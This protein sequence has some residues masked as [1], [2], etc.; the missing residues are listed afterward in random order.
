MH[1]KPALLLAALL[2]HNATAAPRIVLPQASTPTEKFA[3]AELQRYL[4]RVLGADVAVVTESAG[5]PAPGGLA[6]PEPKIAGRPNGEEPFNPL[7]GPADTIFV[8]RCADSLPLLDELAHPIADLRA[9]SFIMAPGADGLRLLGGGDRGT[10]YAVYAFLERQGCRWYAPGPAGEVVPRR[11]AL[12]LP[13]E[14]LLE[15]PG[16]AVRDIGRG[17]GATPEET[18]ALVDWGAKNRLNRM[19]AL[20]QH[21]G[22]AE[23]GG[24]VLWQHV[25]HNTPWVVPNEKYF[26][27]HPEYFAL[28]NGRRIRTGKEGGY[29]CT[30]E[31]AVHQLAA[32]FINRWF[33][34]HPESS[35]VPISPPDGD[36]KW[37][38]CERCL[39]LGGRNFAPGEDG[40]MTRRQVEFINAIAPLVAARH[41]DKYILNLA[42]SRYVWPYPGLRLASNVVTQV[43]HGYAGNGVMVESILGPRNAEAREI[44]RQWAEASPAGIGVWDYFILHVPD[45]SGSPM[46]PLGFGAVARDMARFLAEFP[47]PYKVY[48]TQAGSELHRYNAFLYHA[49]ARFAWNPA[50]DLAELRAGYAD[51]LFGPAGPAVARYLTRLDDAYTAATDWNPPIWREITVPSPRVFTPAA[52]GDLRAALVAARASLPA[53]DA[54]ADALLADLET[55]LAYV[56]SAVRP[57]Q[58][59]ASADGVWRI[60]RGEDAYVFNV[61]GAA[62]SREE[63][64]RVRGDAEARGLL[65]ESLLR[66]LF[67]CTPRS[68]PIVWLENDRLRVGVLPGV[69]GRLI[70]LIDRRT[71]RNLLY[72]PMSVTAL[73]DPGAGYFRYGGYEEYTRKEFASPGWELALEAERRDTDTALGLVLTGVTPDGLRIRRTLTLPR[74][75]SPDLAFR[76]ELENGTAQ[77]RPAMIRVHP[78]LQVART[79]DQTLLLVRGGD[80]GLKAIPV[81]EV[82]SMDDHQPDGWWGV[83]DASSGRGLINTFAAGTATTHLHPDRAHESLNLELFGPAATLAPGETLAFEHRYRAVADWAEAPDE[84]VRLKPRTAAAESQ[85]AHVEFV[86]GRQG[87]GIRVRDTRMLV[88]DVPDDAFWRAGAFE[89]WMRLDRAPTNVADGIL[90]SAGS[91]QPDYTVLAVRDGELVFYRQQARDDGGAGYAAWCKVNAPLPGWTTGAWQHVVATWDAPPGRPATVRLFLDGRP[92]AQR[93]DAQ[94]L[95]FREVGRIAIGCDSASARNPRFPG[96]LDNVRLHRRVLNEKDVQQMYRGLTLPAAPLLQLDFEQSTAPAR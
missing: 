41:P 7:P 58:L 1:L 57:K 14:R 77:P 29:L 43:A 96:V 82:A 88:Y 37:C 74:G 66:V 12:D 81:P 80:G 85:D 26:D 23:R 38:E 72:E 89:A 55:S 60:E 35:V 65:D 39:A 68:E 90:M 25:C 49:I 93:G 73:A 47:N 92:L 91:R 36:V 84:V 2:V 6:P 21:P 44:F 78:E 9:D 13:T 48:F 69:G 50:A 87:A 33:D 64:E 54:R 62:T 61:G 30:T 16:F 56:E 19:Y 71:G 52:L 4:G 27:T 28:Y 94:F 45:Q 75:A 24:Q 22:W 40:H 46:T 70:R 79:L 42:Y 63:I 76:T 51:A 10:L 18:L 67:R 86:P 8:G 32:D 5:D 34:A 11:A 59:V 15:R 31:P 3:A 17:P 95:P 20:R 83:V 53:D